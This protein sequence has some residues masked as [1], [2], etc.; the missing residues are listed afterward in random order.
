MLPT[1]DYVREAIAG[2]LACEH[3]EVAGDGQH[4][5]AL[6]VSRRSRARA[7]SRATSWSTPRSATA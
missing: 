4:F 1:P 3:L 7:A 2:G 6:I 5:E